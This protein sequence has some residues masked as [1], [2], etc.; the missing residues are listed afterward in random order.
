VK[1]NA[2]QGY[3]IKNVQ[4]E[5]KGK[6]SNDTDLLCIRSAVSSKFRALVDSSEEI[7]ISIEQLTSMH[8]DAEP[9][10]PS[11]SAST[12]T[13]LA[14]RPEG[15]SSFAGASSFSRHDSNYIGGQ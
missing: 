15:L 9:R 14:H 7:Q 4:S 11:V 6:Q 5:S 2:A 10:Q 8:L 12:G 3:S 13:S 1:G